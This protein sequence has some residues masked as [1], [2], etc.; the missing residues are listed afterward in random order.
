MSKT[1]RP[2]ARLWIEVAAAPL[3]ALAA[4]LTLVDPVWIETISGA[5]P[6]RG[7]GFLE[8]AIPLSLAFAAIASGMLALREWRRA[9]AVGIGGS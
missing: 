2:R 1:Q 8:A 5:D 9:A 6:D 4:L 3:A 7:S